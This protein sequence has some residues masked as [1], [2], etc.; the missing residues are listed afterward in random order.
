[1]TILPGTQIIVSVWAL[2]M[3]PEHWGADVDEFRPE[4]FF[5][6]ECKKRHPFAYIPFSAGPRNCIGQNLAIMEAK[7]VLGRLLQRFTL[8]IPS[9]QA[10]PGTDRTVIPVRPN[11]PLFLIAKP[12]V[13]IV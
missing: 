8:S 6:E 3:S 13:R 5:P 1:V 11:V 4:R 9:G 7:V 12:R 2:H 10:N